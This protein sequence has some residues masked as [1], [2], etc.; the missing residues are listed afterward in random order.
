M[1]TIFLSA[2]VP[3]PDSNN[4]APDTYNIGLEEDLIVKSIYF[5]ITESVPTRS[6]GSFKEGLTAELGGRTFDVGT[7]HRM[8]GHVFCPVEPLRLSKGSS[9]IFTN[10]SQFH[11]TI[12]VVLDGTYQP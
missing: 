5:N 4:S 11:L 7:I 8:D 2:K 6:P 1:P 9:L 3:A 10:T 12:D